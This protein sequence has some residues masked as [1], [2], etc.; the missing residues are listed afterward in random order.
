MK[1]AAPLATLSLAS[2]ALSLMLVLGAALLA[3]RLRAFPLVRGETWGCGYTAPTA[4]MQYTASSFAQPLTDLFRLVLQTRIRLSPPVGLFPR[5][6]ALHTQTPDTF[7]ERLFRPAFAGIARGLDRLRV[8]Q[9]GRIQIYV[10]YIVLTLI[11]VMVWK[12]G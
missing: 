11:A 10:L 1:E 6:A 12:L 4:R 2:I 7:Q 5:R 9:Q 8:L 3:L